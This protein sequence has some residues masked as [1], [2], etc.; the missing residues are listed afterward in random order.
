MTTGEFNSMLHDGSDGII[1]L[2][3]SIVFTSFSLD[4]WVAILCFSGGSRF[5]DCVGEKVEAAC[6]FLRELAKLI[7]VTTLDAYRT[8]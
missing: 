3:I 2:R 7:F 8:S 1:F 6:W 4:F 5:E